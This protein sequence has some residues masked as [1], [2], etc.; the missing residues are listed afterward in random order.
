MSRVHSLGV[1]V[2][3]A[4]GLGPVARGQEAPQ[5]LVSV[6]AWWTETE[7]QSVAARAAGIPVAA[8]NGQHMEFAWIPAGQFVMGSPEN[9]DGRGADEGQHEVTLTRSFY[10]A[11]TEVTQA[12]WRA[13]METDPSSFRSVG[14]DAPVEQVSWQDAVDFCNAL[15]EAGGLTRA[16]GADGRIDPA[17]SGYRL[18]TEAEWEYACRAGTQTAY[19]YGNEIRTDQANYNGMYQSSGVDRQTTVAVASFPPN[20]WGLC[21]LLGNVWEWCSDGYGAYPSG[22]AVD[23]QGP[24]AAPHRVLR[25]GAWSHVAPYCRSATR[26]WN[27][28]GA[29]DRR[30]GF[31]PVRMP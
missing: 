6:P 21:D 1:L 18:P 26:H 11:R 4:L 9:E 20:P 16:Y 23:P 31:R 27:D 3:L 10:M 28:P 13:V 29:R 22:P 12:Q 25:G 5:G 19:P 7:G 2:A 8:R 14:E 17:A 24:D 30:H 15:S